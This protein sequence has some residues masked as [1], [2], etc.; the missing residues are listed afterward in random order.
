MK[1]ELQTSRIT[2]SNPTVPPQKRG[3]LAIKL[4]VSVAIPLAI[5]IILSFVYTAVTTHT[6]MMAMKNNILTEESEVIS[7]NVDTYFAAYKG[8]LQTMMSD[9]AF[10]ALFDEI[11]TSSIISQAD[12]RKLSHYRSAMDK[13]E[14]IAAS[15]TK[16]IDLAYIIE[17]SKCYLV[18]NGDAAEYFPDVLERDY[19]TKAKT[20]GGIVMCDPYIS[21]VSNTLVVPMSAPVY[22]ATG[23][24][25]GVA[26]LD[27]GLSALDTILTQYDSKEGDFF[28]VVSENGNVIHNSYLGDFAPD[29][30]FESGISQ[31]LINRLGKVSTDVLELTLPDGA[32]VHC[33]TN[34]VGD[35]GWY[36][37]TG[38][39]D[40]LYTAE[41]TAQN[42]RQTACYFCG[43]FGSRFNTDIDDL[44][45][46]CCEAGS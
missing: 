1:K 29:N 14:A 16:T 19:Y 21:S 13:L 39:S 38:M 11:E 7:N 45:F 26:A 3:K 42:Y 43:D 31:E 27:F 12:V 20:A 34:V 17:T 46:L 6:S 44:Q 10:V 41:A 28:I 22:N 33:T 37:I 5:L 24:L 9:P 23:T 18:Y 32:L 30:I 15:D 4:T 8:I 35:W 25:T 40:E 36:V 2:E